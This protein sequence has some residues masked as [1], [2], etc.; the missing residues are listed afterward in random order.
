MDYTVS[1]AV[2]VKLVMIV[3]VKSGRSNGPAGVIKS[4]IHLPNLG[5][6]S[7]SVPFFR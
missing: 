4:S 3:D 2:T 5:H 6:W 1:E 7:H